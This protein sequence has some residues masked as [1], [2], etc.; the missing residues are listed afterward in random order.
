MLTV[1]IAISITDDIQIA[2]ADGYDR[3]NTPGSKPRLQRYDR[4]MQPLMSL[5]E[6][7]RLLETPVLS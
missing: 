1:E 6:K 3:E 5:H 2:R 4:A 7:V